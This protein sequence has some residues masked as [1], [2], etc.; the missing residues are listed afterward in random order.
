M[1]GAMQSKVNKANGERA[2]RARR[3]AEGLCIACASRSAG[4][5]LCRLCAEK[6]NAS[7]RGKPRLPT[8]ERRAKAA[9][10]QRGYCA[11]R[12]ALGLC[13]RCDSARLKDGRLCAACRERHSIEMRR[14]NAAK[15]EIARLIAADA[16]LARRRIGERGCHGLVGVPGESQDR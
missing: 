7:R 8:V 11:K 16:G 2:R 15:R 13:L 3:R 14:N 4:R 5:Q 9:E 12:F 1:E 10:W 6:A